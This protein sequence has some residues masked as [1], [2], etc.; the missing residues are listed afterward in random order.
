MAQLQGAVYRLA[1]GPF[2]DISVG[3]L[4][5]N[6]VNTQ[7]CMK[8]SQETVSSQITYLT[9]VCTLRNHKRKTSHNVIEI[10]PYSLISH[11]GP[12]SLV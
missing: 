8:F 10:P 1:T 4:V 7:S 11:P 12:F 2:P 3:E 9:Y 6:L 5:L